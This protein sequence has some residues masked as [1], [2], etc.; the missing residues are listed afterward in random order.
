M[1]DSEGISSDSSEDS[2]EKNDLEDDLMA[3]D[4]VQAAIIRQLSENGMGSFRSSPR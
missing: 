2:L 1:S 3:F 4:S